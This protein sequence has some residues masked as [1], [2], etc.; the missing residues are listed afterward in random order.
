[1]FTRAGRKD[2]FS[3]CDWL[4]MY[5]SKL[6]ECTYNTMQLNREE[7]KKLR[8]RKYP[9]RKPATLTIQTKCIVCI[10]NTDIRASER[11]NQRP[12]GWEH[13]CTGVLWKSPAADSGT[14]H[15]VIL[16]SKVMIMRDQN[17][18]L[19]CFPQGQYSNSLPG[20]FTWKTDQSPCKV[21]KP[22]KKVAKCYES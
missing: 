2:R 16:L 4:T 7:I 14:H 5:Q 19:G 20:Q 18:D 8:K 21:Q 3:S 9:S 15:P 1:M 12:W 6:P 11:K 22:T 17:H 10:E 13:S